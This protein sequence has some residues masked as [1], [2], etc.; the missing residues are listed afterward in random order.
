MCFTAGSGGMYFGAGVV[1]AYLASRRKAPRVAAGISAGAL[2]AAALQKC[3]ADLEDAEPARTNAT[4]AK[5]RWGWF[6]RYLRA[7]TDN[8]LSVPWDAIPDMS[9]FFADMPPIRDTSLSA[10]D[11]AGARRQRYILIKIGRWLAN[12]GITVR[13]V[14]ET[15]VN[16]VRQ[17]EGYGISP[18]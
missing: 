12:L 2:S 13:T 10:K 5:A 3:Y 11:E 9:D 4:D 1:H 16:Y 8:P 15:A 14:A 7:L 6:R 18:D 17:K